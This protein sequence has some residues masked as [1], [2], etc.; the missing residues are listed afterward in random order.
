M[1]NMQ[2]V[3]KLPIP[4]LIKELYPVPSKYVGAKL[5]RDDEIEA[6]FK[7][8]VNKFL[9]II[10]P[11][12]ADRQ[13][14]ILCYL[15]KLKRVAE[16]VQGKII[17][18]PRVFTNKPRTSGIGYMG[19]LHQ[20]NPQETPDLLKGLIAIRKLH[21]S[22]LVDF[23]FTC[24][25][26]LLYPENYRYLSDLLSYV[27]IGARS[28]ENQFHRLVASGLNVPVG[29]KN[30]ISGNLDAMI[31]AVNAAR[32]SHAFLYRG[33]EVVTSGNELSH[34]VLRGYVDFNGV[35]T[36]NYQYDNL[37]ETI[38]KL[39][40]KIKAPTAII[41]D[42]SHS[43]S[44]KQYERQIDIA[45]DVMQSRAKNRK[46]EQSVKGLM[47]ESYLQDGKQNVGDMEFGKSITDACL[48]WDKTENLIYKI[49][50][51]L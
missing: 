16:N 46:I 23:G 20:P 22:A 42:A 34:V 1:E 37:C 36:A 35:N 32:T 41:V 51:M 29:M 6:V 40:E 30:P 2:F 50:E 19:M 49:A 8:Q 11:C 44:N 13:D 33:W 47:I 39:Q 10:G 5:I 43:N 25:D 26:E 28:V 4:K 27:T 9:L 14:A 12:S 21:L 38:D 18:I 31:N 17:I 24:A 7:N 3:R 45:L 15:E 48:G